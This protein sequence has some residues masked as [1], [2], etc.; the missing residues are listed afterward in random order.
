MGGR[1]A[2]RALAQGFAV[3]TGF[4]GVVAGA[5]ALGVWGGVHM[6]RALGWRPI[7]FTIG[8]GVIGGAAA[9]RI[10]LASLAA[11]ERKDRPNGPGQAEGLGP[12]SEPPAEC[13]GGGRTETGDAS[14]RRP[15]GR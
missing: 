10:V 1:H 11:L 12:R 9:L 7:G 14:R 15:S 3:A 6:D 4:G 2:F 5:V 8:L 13:E